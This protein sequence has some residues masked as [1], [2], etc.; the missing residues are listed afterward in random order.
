MFSN[1]EHKHRKKKTENIIFTYFSVFRCR[2]E[3]LS[4]CFYS[5]FLSLKPSDITFCLQQCQPLA[6]D[7]WST[8]TG[9]QVGEKH[10]KEE[11]F[12]RD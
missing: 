4:A 9:Q 6:I 11:Q 12:T 10:G 2:D 5:W 8:R 7:D 1:Y 3:T